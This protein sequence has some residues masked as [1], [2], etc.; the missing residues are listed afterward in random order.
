MRWGFFRFG[1]MTNIQMRKLHVRTRTLGR[2]RNSYPNT[3]DQNCEIRDA[4]TKYNRSRKMNLAGFDDSSSSSLIRID[5]DVEKLLTSSFDRLKLSRDAIRLSRVKL[6]KV[7]TFRRD[8]RM[9]GRHSSAG[10]TTEKRRSSML[11]EA[12]QFSTH[13]P[14]RHYHPI[15]IPHVTYNNDLSQPAFVFTRSRGDSALVSASRDHLSN[16]KH[17]RS[18]AT[19]RKVVRFCDSR[20]SVRTFEVDQPIIS[21]NNKTKI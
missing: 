9:C 15:T 13:L 17:H 3:I 16:V 20:K 8:C 6:P 4:L 18:A 21:T 7:E 2:L 1:E 12:P 11:T 14:H 19:S 5:D 10:G